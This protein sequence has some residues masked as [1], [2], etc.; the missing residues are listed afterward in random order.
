MLLDKRPEKIPDAADP[1]SVDFSKQH[2]PTFQKG[3][4]Q[5]CRKSV[6]FLRNFV[7][8]FQLRLKG[9]C[10]LWLLEQRNSIC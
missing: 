8:N 7:K 3:C 9:N 1:D 5:Y 10:L 4:Y 6:K 2:P